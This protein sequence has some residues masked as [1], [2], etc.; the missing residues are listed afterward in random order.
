M[1]VRALITMDFDG[2]TIAGAPRGWDQELDGP[3]QGLPIVPVVDVQTGLTFLYSVWRPDADELAM[4]AAGGALRLK[5]GTR[6]H[7]L[8][9][10]EALTPEAVRAAGCRDWIDMNA[11]VVDEPAK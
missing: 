1:G 5:I 4:L 11:P 8:V 10:L 9:N 6:Q 2:S 3:V 7:P